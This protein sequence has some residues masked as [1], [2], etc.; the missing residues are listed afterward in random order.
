M[1]INETP[2]QSNTLLITLTFV[3]GFSDIP[4][5]FFNSLILEIEAFKSSVASG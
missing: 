1:T 5:F 4:T 3:S 2:T